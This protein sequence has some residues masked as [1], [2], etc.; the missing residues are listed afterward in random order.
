MTAAP[1]LDFLLPGDPHTLTGGY[2]YD[3]RITEGLRA[4]GW[5]V[6]LR[7]LDASF[8]WPT[9]GALQQA[10]ATLAGLPAG[11]IVVIDGLALGAMPELLA[12]HAQRLRLV[13]LIHHP[14]AA[15]RGLSDTRRAALRRSEQRALGT[16]HRTLVTSRWTQRQLAGYG[17]DAD[18]IGVIEPGTDPRPAGPRLRRHVAGAALRGNAHTPQGPCGALR[19]ARAAARP[20]LAPELRGQPQARSP[21]RRRPARTDH[22]IGSGAAHRAAWGGHPRRF[23]GTLR[24]RRSVRPRF[25]P[26]GLRHGGR[27]SGLAG[28]AAGVQRPPAPCRKPPRRAPHGSCLSATARRWRMRWRSS[29]TIRARCAR[30][31]PPRAGPGPACAPGIR[32]APSSPPSSRRWR[33]A[34]RLRMAAL[35]RTH[36]CR[37]ARPRDGADAQTGAARSAG[38]DHRPGLRHGGQSALPEPAHRRSSGMVADR[39]RPG[40]ARGDPRMHAGV[41]RGAPR[42]RAPRRR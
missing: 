27:R 38:A 16:V 7:S 3:R 39:P 19:G 41:D 30:S 21:H 35:A 9:V 23:G 10:G 33:D 20:A 18:R 14:L 17:V 1:A 13:A 6:N 26:G 22:P 36:R 4:L 25:V 32:P 5:R 2:A 37:L 34:V 31:R 42:E 15:E 40:A 12:T 28:S 8:P 24:P 29:W 11:R